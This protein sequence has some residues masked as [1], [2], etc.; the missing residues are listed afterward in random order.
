MI[1]KKR[2][3][4]TIILAVISFV[5]CT[6]CTETT[7][8]STEIPVEALLAAP[9]S[10]TLDNQ[11]VRLST[12]ISRNFMPIIEP[13][14]APMNTTAYIETTDG[15]VINS[16]IKSEVVYFV[17][18]RKS[19]KADFSDESINEYMYNPSRLVKILR[20]GPKLDPNTYVD[21][22]VNIKYNN[23]NYLLRA[24]NQKVNRLD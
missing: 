16:K 17:Y 7:E 5:V 12:Y 1:I 20:N 9:L 2:N 15:S 23:H 10:V 22:I 13:T 8:P 3:L 19:W 6:Y 21:V 14:G 11:S 18:N 24:E 4:R